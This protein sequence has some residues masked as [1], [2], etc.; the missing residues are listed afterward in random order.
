MLTEI[1]SNLEIKE[2]VFN[3]NKYGVSGLD[4]CGAFFFQY[5]WDIIHRDV[6]MIVKKLFISSW[7][8][9]NYN[10]NTLILLPKVPN[11][12]FIELFRSIALANL[13]FKIISKVL[14]GRLSPIF[15][16]IISKEQKGF[17][18]GICV[19]DCIG[20]TSEAVNLM[21]KKSYELERCIK[22]F[23]WS[24][25]LNKSKLA[26]MAWSKVCKKFDQGGLG[27]RSISTLNEAFNMK[28]AWD[29]LSSSKNWAILLKARVL[30]DD[31]P[32]K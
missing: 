23:I 31:R 14:A 22:N 20:L 28:M 15:P 24:G 25:D 18:Q 30:R 1:P 27:L 10:S 17:V 6:I 8:M 2:A 16:S 3:L 29:L 4:S 11:V 7:I 21:H 12:D 19:K 26:I 13:K 9:P 32:I 5:F